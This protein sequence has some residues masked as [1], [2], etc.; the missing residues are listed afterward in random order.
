MPKRIIQSRGRR[1]YASAIGFDTEDEH[2]WRGG[3]RIPHYNM[4][5]GLWPWVLHRI[6]DGVEAVDTVRWGYEPPVAGSRMRTMVQYGFAA[7]E[8]YFRHMW[9]LGRCIVPIDGWYEFDDTISK[10]VPWYVCL[11]GRNTML[12]PAITNFRPY[13]ACPPGTGFALITAGDLG[14]SDKRDHRPVILMPDAARRWIDP[15]TSVDEATQIVC[16]K[17]LSVG[18]FHAYRVRPRVLDPSQNDPH[19]I[20]ADTP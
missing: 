9:R 10:P 6:P 11:R 20:D 1:E 7:T 19:L 17:G 16:T 5:P 13:T 15:A 18:A 3:D 12:A 8:K 2:R 14:I 4:P